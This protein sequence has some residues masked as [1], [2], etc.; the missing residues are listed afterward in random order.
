[1]RSSVADTRLDVPRK[2]VAATLRPDCNS[3]AVDWKRRLGMV[4]ERALV[5]ANLTKQEASFAMGYPDQSAISRWIAGTEP[6]QWHKL[7][8][9][10]VLRPWIPVALAEQ[11]GAEVQTTVIVRRLA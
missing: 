4:I 2:A 8:A 6:T 1:M 5:L 11:S 9:I 7:M 3:L 10:D